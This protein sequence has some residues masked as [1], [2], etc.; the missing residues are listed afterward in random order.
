[1][2]QHSIVTAPVQVEKLVQNIPQLPFTSFI[3]SN[4]SDSALARPVLFGNFLKASKNLNSACPGNCHYPLA[5]PLK[6]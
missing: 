3:K 5:L 6:K 4:L 1:M 2:A